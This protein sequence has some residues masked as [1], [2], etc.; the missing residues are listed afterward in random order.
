MT[1]VGDLA[2]WLHLRKPRSDAGPADPVIP[3]GDGPLVLLCGDAAALPGLTQALRR[4]RPGLRLGTL[5]PMAV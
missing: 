5:G 3:A 4:A 2:S 1:G